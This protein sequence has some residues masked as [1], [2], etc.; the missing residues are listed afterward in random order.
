MAARSN[1]LNQLQ[2]D[3][4]EL[5]A[6]A[7]QINSALID[8]PEAADLAPF[9]EAR[10]RMPWPL[11]GA[12]RASFGQT[13][14]SG[15]LRRQ[16][17]IIATEVGTAV[18][19]IHPGRVV[20]ADWLRGSGNLVIVDHGNSY[21][22]LYAHNQQLTKQAGDWVNRGEALALSGNNAGDGEPGLYLEIRR[23]SQPL[24]PADWLTP[25]R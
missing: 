5:Q 14:S 2:Q 16:G 13:Y 12:V 8:I 21:L 23:N 9:A 3:Q 1:E 19:A 6:L 18:R 15:Q 20:F 11:T 10:G 17:L 22:S 24:N 25:A 7:E 4:A